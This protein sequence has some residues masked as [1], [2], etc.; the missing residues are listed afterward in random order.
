M[1]RRSRSRASAPPRERTRA[2]VA[3]RR[4]QSAATQPPP[5]APVPQPTAARRS[6]R[7]AAPTPPWG[8][9]PLVELCALAAIGLGVWGLVVHN[10]VLLTGAAFLGSVAGIEVA[11]REHLGGFRSH[12]LV[13]TGTVTVATLALLLFAGVARG[14]VLIVGPALLLVGYVGFRELFKRRSGG[15]GMRVR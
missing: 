2:A 13:L 6:R 10:G 5:P 15:V 3:P 14:T 7:D 12:S 1:G 4:E 11:L 9:F 8:S